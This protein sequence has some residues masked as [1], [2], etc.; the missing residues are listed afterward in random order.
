MRAFDLVYV[1]TRGG[2]GDTTVTPSFLIYSRAFVTGEVGYAAAVAVVLACI[3][4]L[5]AAGIGRLLESR[6][7]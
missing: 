7:G 3:V 4:F 2:P 6:E 5:V 1:T